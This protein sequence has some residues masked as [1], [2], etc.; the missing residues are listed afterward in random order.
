MHREW[1]PKSFFRH[2][3]PEVVTLFTG[4][5]GVNL[6]VNDKGPPGDQLYRAWKALPEDQQ[7]RLETELLP[8]NDMCSTHAR[9]YLENTARAVWTNGKANLVEESRA[10]TTQDLALRLFI[11]SRRSFFDAYKNYTVDSMEHGTEYRGRR[12][13]ALEPSSTSKQQMREAMQ[14]H[15][16]ETALGARCQIEDYANKEKFALFVY[17]EDEV[18]PMDRFN[19][20]GVVA[21]EWQRPVLRIAAVFHFETATLQVKAARKVEREK[22]RDLFAKIFVGEPDYF[23]DTSKN[24]KFCFDPLRSPNFD[25]PT[26]LADKIEDVC[27]VKIVARPQHD[28]VR[29]ISIQ[30]KPGL[31]VKETHEALDGYGIDLTND[32]VEGVQLRFQF[33]GSGRSKWR[34][35]SLFN[36]GSSNLRDTDRD[37]VIRRYLK[38]WGID[39]TV[40][41][42]AVAA[43]ILQDTAS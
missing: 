40:H 31:S 39:A 28:D 34:T 11:D 42:A 5:S 32:V 37:R 12:H 14:Q 24:P 19:T 23:E 2:L 7:R 30:L 8:V 15:F 6:M 25:F 27:V 16:R 21:P 20:E 4:S 41:Q 22:L 33:E 18:T 35:V 3:T 9:P 43:P 13:V 29:R 26:R 1:N 17:Y 36:P 38:E 10:W